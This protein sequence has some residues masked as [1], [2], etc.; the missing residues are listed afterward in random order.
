MSEIGQ[1]CRTIAQEAVKMKHPCIRITPAYTNDIEDWA[2]LYYL[3]S[4]TAKNISESTEIPVNIDI[5]EKDTVQCSS[6]PDGTHEM[7]EFSNEAMVDPV[8]LCIHCGYYLCKTTRT[9][10][11]LKEHFNKKHF[12][13]A[14]TMPRAEEDELPF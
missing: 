12:S 14:N 6:S 8:L 4:E 11:Q 5:H 2:K 13:R 9:K 1:I 7:M 3:F 10:E